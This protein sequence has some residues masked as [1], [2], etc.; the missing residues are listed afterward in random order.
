LDRDGKG[1]LTRADIPH[2]HQMTL[3]RG[4]ADRGGAGAAAAIFDLYR[5]TA[6]YDSDP[7]PGR[8]PLWFRKMDRNRDGD[9]SR[10]EWLFS[11]E[12]F[13][14]IDTDGDGLISVEEAERYDELIR[15]QQK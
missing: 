6:R 1:F 3:R 5:V 9:V 13:R 4:P 12:E 8:G 10:K 11:D 7:G 14:K 15:K 2:L